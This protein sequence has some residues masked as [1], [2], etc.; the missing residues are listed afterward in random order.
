MLYL[1]GF[2]RQGSA[3]SLAVAFRRLT[4]ELL[5]RGVDEGRGRARP[6]AVADAHNPA[7]IVRLSPLLCAGDPHPFPRTLWRAA[8]EPFD[9]VA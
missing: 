8:I 5:D 9:D 7:L 1:G 6:N 3:N 2:A 4:R